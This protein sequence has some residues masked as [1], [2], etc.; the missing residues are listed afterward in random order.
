MK[1]EKL[2]SKNEYPVVEEELNQTCQQF[3]DSFILAW[4][5]SDFKMFSEI[6]KK[7][8]M[9]IDKGFFNVMGIKGVFNRL[10]LYTFMRETINGKNIAIDAGVFTG[11]NNDP[12][13]FG[14]LIYCPLNQEAIYVLKIKLQ[15][16]KISRIETLYNHYSENLKYYYNF[17]FAEDKE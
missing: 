5:T 12:N 14:V 7:N 4:F 16:G 8:I 3:F 9:M 6:V 13:I 11:D 15:K 2:N 10:D 17:F 1:T